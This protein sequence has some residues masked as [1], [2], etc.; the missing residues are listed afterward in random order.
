MCATCPFRP[1]SKYALLAIDLAKSAL[2]YASRIC[3]STGSNGIHRKT[4]KP[5]HL[6]RGARNIQLNAMAAFMEIDAPTD[7]AWNNRR[8]ALGM[9]RTQIKDPC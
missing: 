7:A 8:V 9:T 5:E 2:T 3:H 4:G 1:G 6:C